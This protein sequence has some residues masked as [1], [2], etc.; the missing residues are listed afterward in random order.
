MLF[1]EH[2]CH[3]YAKQRIHYAITLCIITGTRNINGISVHGLPFYKQFGQ[4][5]LNVLKLITE[6]CTCELYVVDDW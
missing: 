5:K 2:S 1:R 4:I 3:K 6:L